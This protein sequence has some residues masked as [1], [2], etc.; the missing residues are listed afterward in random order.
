MPPSYKRFSTAVVRKQRPGIIGGMRTTKTLL[1]LVTLA[2][3]Y[4]VI[5]PVPLSLEPTQRVRF[6]TALEPHDD[7]ETPGQNQPGQNQP[8]EDQRAPAT[9]ELRGDERVPGA[10]LRP[11][12]GPG[13]FGYL[14]HDGTVKQSEPISYGVTI[15]DSHYLTYD[16]AP[17]ELVVRAPGGAE[18]AA[19][20]RSG[21]PIA[22]QE[23]VYVLDRFQDGVTAYELQFGSSGG[24]SAEPR[25]LWSRRFSSPVTDLDAAADGSLL[26]GLLDGTAEYISPDGETVQFGRGHSG[27]SRSEVEAVYAVALSPD[28]GMA[29]VLTGLRPQRLLVYEI[30]AERDLELLHTRE[31]EHARRGPSLLRFAPAGDRLVYEHGTVLTEVSMRS[32]EHA[33]LGLPAAVGSLE[34]GTPDRPSAFVVRGDEMSEL[35]V[36]APNRSTVMQSRLPGED[37]F[38]TGGDGCYVL[39][40]EEVL[41]CFE[42]TDG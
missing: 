20:P 30:S 31:L 12:R 2:L 6:V 25:E 36:L 1:L 35:L 15:T 37:V 38:V 29:A 42:I 27:E 18:V 24:A 4:A 3:L 7:H 13:R 33:E 21:Y 39:G 9:E 40:I 26:L 16:R 17:Q 23:R 41:V 34:L 19:L 32:F 11:F 8:G 10:E 5:S 14:R 22:A 28:A